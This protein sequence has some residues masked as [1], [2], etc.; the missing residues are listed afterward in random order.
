MN[1]LI[2]SWSATS[3]DR[4]FFPSFLCRVF[5]ST[6]R[7]LFTLATL[8]SLLSLQGCLK[9]T[10]EVDSCNTTT[11]LHTDP[12]SPLGQAIISG[13]NLINYNKAVTLIELDSVKSRSPNPPASFTD[14]YTASTAYVQGR[15][16]FTL[17]PKTVSSNQYI[18]YIHGGAYVVGL[19][20][21]YYSGIFSPVLDRTG[22]T[23]IAPDYGIAPYYTYVQ[24]F[25][26]MQAVYDSLVARVGAQR[27][28]LMGDSAGAGLALGFAQSLQSQGKSQPRQIILLSPWLDIT[29]ANP[30]IKNIQDPVLNAQSL[31]E[32]GK[33]WAGSS[34]P[35]V[36]Q[37][38]PINGPLE[39]LARINLFIGGRDMFLP[40]VIKLRDLMSQR[41]FPLT[42]YEYPQ[43]FHVWMN[44]PVLSEAKRA[45]DEIADLINSGQ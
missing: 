39:G 32:A 21:G 25:A 38:S 15:R 42:V 40:D 1:L 45:H 27:I 4:P 13:A 5:R 36:Y 35:S 2:D 16:V 44:F 17:T 24:G 33:S 41:C 37:V 20:E 12:V 29:L 23:I 19:A 28:T 43:M 9:E 30:A 3:T 22:A 26:L 10:L 7:S 18:L 14:T 34:D 31:R 11:K 8:C 6:S